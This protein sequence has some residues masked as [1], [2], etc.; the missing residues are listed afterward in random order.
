[1]S[2]VTSYAFALALF[3][4]LRERRLRQLNTVRGCKE[5]AESVG[6][7]GQIGDSLVTAPLRSV[8]G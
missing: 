4:G 2:V 3:L 1:M 8:V 5:I 6:V 7:A